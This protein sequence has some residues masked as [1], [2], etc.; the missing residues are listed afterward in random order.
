ML[1]T[2]I[3]IIRVAPHPFQTPIIAASTRLIL[4]QQQQHAAEIRSETIE[5]QKLKFNSMELDIA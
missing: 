3:V 5:S 1:I 2:L 4:P